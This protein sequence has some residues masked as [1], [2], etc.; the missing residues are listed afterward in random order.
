M[1][2][3]LAF[4][5]QDWTNILA[6]YVALALRQASE[7]VDTV[8]PFPVKFLLHLQIPKLTLLSLRYLEPII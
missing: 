6:R 7:V 3:L 5:Q 1:D 8:Q 2:T 4:R